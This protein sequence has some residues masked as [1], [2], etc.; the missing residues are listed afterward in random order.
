MIVRH[1]TGVA[2]SAADKLYTIRTEECAKNGNKA[3][4]PK[5]KLCN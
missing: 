5:M 4:I 3:L 2:A 1:Y